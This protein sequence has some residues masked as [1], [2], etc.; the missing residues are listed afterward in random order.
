VQKGGEGAE[1]GSQAGQTAEEGNILQRVASMG[2]IGTMGS[3]KVGNGM[4]Y[5]G[6]LKGAV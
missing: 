3:P 4:L 5:R 6:D 1:Q 2:R